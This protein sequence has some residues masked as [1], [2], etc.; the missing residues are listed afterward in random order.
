MTASQTFPNGRQVKWVAVA[1]AG[2]GAIEEVRCLWLRSLVGLDICVSD[3][4]HRQR[5]AFLKSRFCSVVFTLVGESE[6][7]EDG[8]SLFGPR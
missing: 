7:E 4:D 1:G 2:T 6:V 5:D 3:G 8:E